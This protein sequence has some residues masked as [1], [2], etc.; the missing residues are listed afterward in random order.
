MRTRLVERAR[1]GDE[2]AFTE[3]VDLDGDLCYAIA[4]RILRD[5][6]R[7]QDAVQ[8]AFL[9]AWRELPRLR[10]PERF[11]PWLH[12]LLVNACY[13]ELRRHR[14]WS[15]RIKASCRSTDRAGPIP[16]SRSTTATPS[17]ERSSGSRPNTARSSSCIT[18]PAYPLA[19]IAEIVGVP[20]GTVKSRLHTP[21]RPC[22]RRSSLTARSTARRH[23]WH[24]RPR[25]PDAILAAWLDEGPTGS[26]RPRARADRG[27]IGTR[28]VTTRLRSGVPWRYRHEWSISARPRGDGRR[29]RRRR[30]ALRARTVAANVGAPACH[31][32]AVRIAGADPPHGATRPLGIRRRPPTTWTQ[33]VTS[34]DSATRSR[35][36]A[37]WT[38]TEPASPTA[39]G[40]D[41]FIA[42]G[43]PPL[44]ETY[45]A[46]D[47]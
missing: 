22:A 33:A 16:R 2:V 13:E 32:D 34:G 7:A 45:A 27:A 20:V 6:E 35:Y 47:H 29:G 31:G 26:P 11:G 1:D 8:Q 19:E 40:I 42:P 21:P 4:F 46:A 23:D 44:S 5:A 25:D 28:S 24:D 41:A 12:R 9:L 3:L 10:D 38:V 17:T 15:T 18:T 39:S 14:R 37:G 36:P 43:G 30:R